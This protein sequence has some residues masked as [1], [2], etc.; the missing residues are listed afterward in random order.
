MFDGNFLQKNTPGK[1][2]SLLLGALDPISIKNTKN[3]VTNETGSKFLALINNA[4]IN[5]GGL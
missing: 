2:G 1:I 4:E 5:F 3:T